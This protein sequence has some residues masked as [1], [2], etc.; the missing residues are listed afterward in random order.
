[1]MS[2]ARLI[3]CVPYLRMDIIPSFSC[4]GALSFKDAKHFVETVNWKT[5]LHTA[6]CSH[7]HKSISLEQNYIPIAADFIFGI[8]ETLGHLQMI[9]FKQWRI[10]R[11]FLNVKIPVTVSTS[12]AIYFVLN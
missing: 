7:V 11:R 2:P 1:M 4:S 5:V 8:D 6:L 3:N 9:F 10:H 12:T